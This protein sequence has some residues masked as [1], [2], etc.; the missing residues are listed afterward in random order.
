[1]Q[2]GKRND[3]TMGNCA[4]FYLSNRSVSSI[5]K[6]IFDIIKKIDIYP[7]IKLINTAMK[8]IICSNTK[9][10]AIVDD[11]FFSFLICLHNFQNFNIPCFKKILDIKVHKPYSRLE[12]SSS[13]SYFLQPLG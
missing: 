11:N 8:L 2:K 10:L 7:Y 4:L 9:Y 3:A 6:V 5:I 13:I 12:G 1:M